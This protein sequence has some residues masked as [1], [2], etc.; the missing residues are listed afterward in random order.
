MILYKTLGGL[1]AQSFTGL[2]DYSSSVKESKL[3]LQELLTSLAFFREFSVATKLVSKKPEEQFTVWIMKVVGNCFFFSCKSGKSFNRENDEDYVAALKMSKA[4]KSR[5]W[6]NKKKTGKLLRLWLIENYALRF[7]EIGA[8]TVN[9]TNTM[10]NTLK[11][12]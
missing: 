2:C 10:E 6:H 4:Q 1:V 7:I 3:S 12:R 9:A 5:P 8:G 11:L